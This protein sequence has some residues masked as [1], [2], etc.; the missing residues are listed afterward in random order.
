M[1]NLWVQSNP[2]EGKYNEKWNEM[3]YKIWEGRNQIG[4]MDK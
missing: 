3:K 1:D 2:Y 4:T